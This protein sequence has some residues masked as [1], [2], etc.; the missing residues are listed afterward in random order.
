MKIYFT[1]SSLILLLSTQIHAS[2]DVHTNNQTLTSPQT[3][4]TI[5]HESKIYEKQ[6]QEQQ[7]LPSLNCS[8]KQVHFKKNKAYFN[9]HTPSDTTKI[10]LIKNNDALPLILDH[11]KQDVGVGAGWMSKIDSGKWS[12]LV[13]TEKDFE[14]VCSIEK[15][16][17]IAHKNCSSSLQICEVMHNITVS[18][19]NYWML[20]NKS[21][22]QVK[23]EVMF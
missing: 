2:T 23:N 19:G 21:W 9:K 6:A 18:P 12:V 20:E 1:I 4:K 8:S 11:Q 16:G 7:S 15:F 3:C 5:L 14:L 13:L 10:Y 22:N 17:E